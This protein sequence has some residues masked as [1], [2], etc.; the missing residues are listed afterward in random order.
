MLC[1]KNSP[2]GSER[3]DGKVYLQTSRA[4]IIKNGRSRYVRG[5][6]NG[7]SQRSF[8]TEDLATKLD[9]QVLRKTQVALKMSG[10]IS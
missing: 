2:S 7:G 9:L 6:L 4:F 3:N 10:N 8:I 1:D 5:I